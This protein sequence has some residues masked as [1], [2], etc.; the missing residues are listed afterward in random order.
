MGTVATP[1]VRVVPVAFE[2]MRE[3]EALEIKA[4]FECR[5]LFAADAAVGHLLVPLRAGKTSDRRERAAERTA[6]DELQDA[7]AYLGHGG[8]PLC[9][10]L[11]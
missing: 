5:I 11:D 3:K 10:I 9:S 4:G 2:A 1:V 6:H 7:V 8:P